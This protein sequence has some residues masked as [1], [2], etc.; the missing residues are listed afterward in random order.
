MKKNLPKMFHNPINRNITNNLG[1]YSTISKDKTPLYQEVKPNRFDIE[2]KIYHLLKDK[3]S[4]SG[5]NVVISTNRGIFKRKMIGYIK[6]NIVTIDN[7][8]FS[9]EE[10]MDIK[11]E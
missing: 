9:I 10:I 7:E 8:H 3:T 2:Q 5:V 1:V 11:K 4:I 6:N